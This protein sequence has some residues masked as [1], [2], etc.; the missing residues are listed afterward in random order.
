MNLYMVEV[1]LP[2][3]FTPE[4]MALIPAQ[5]KMVAKQFQAGTIRSYTLNAR[6]TK[7][8]AMM[9]AE[10][11]DGIRDAL[12]EWPMIGFMSPEI[13]GLFF[14]ETAQVALPAISMN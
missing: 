11:E 5:Q 8:W 10:N 4:F 14:H 3:E 12:D 2:L 7:L 13:H 6:R 9:A 1:D